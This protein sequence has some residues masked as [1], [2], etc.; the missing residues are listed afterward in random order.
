MSK[1]VDEYKEWCELRKD[2]KMYEAGYEQFKKWLSF[3]HPN[4]NPEVYK[5]HILEIKERP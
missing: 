4:E 5:N 3:E 2:W 1:I